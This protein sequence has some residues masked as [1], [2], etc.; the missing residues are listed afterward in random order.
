MKKDVPYFCYSHLVAKIQVSNDRPSAPKLQS[1]T[2]PPVNIVR[3]VLTAA[4]INTAMTMANSDRFH[5]QFKFGKSNG[6]WTINGETWESQ[7]IAASD[8]GQNTWEVWK[9]SSGGGWFHP[10]HIHLVDFFVIK[11]DRDGG[12]RSYE[13]MTPKDVV[14][15]GPSNDLFVIA[16]FGAHK[17]DYMFHCHNLIHEDDDMMRAFSV[18]DTSKGKNSGSGS[19]YVAINNVIYNN[20]KYSDPLL[21][22]TNAKRTTEVVPLNGSLALSTLNKNMYRIFYPTATDLKEYNG[23]FNP[24]QSQV[25]PMQ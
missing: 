20:W 19:R 9:F 18:V 11:R 24:W 21:G 12:V 23:A 25:C 1:Q 17:G 10:I 14:Y 2:N 22:E 6:Q 5:R 8:V 16:R 7:K 15:L 3:K 4:D 13:Q